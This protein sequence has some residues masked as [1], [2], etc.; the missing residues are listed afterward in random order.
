[1]SKLKKLKKQHKQ[2]KTKSDISF[3][4]LAVS[5]TSFFGLIFTGLG[6]NFNLIVI[7]LLPI[8]VGFLA[9]TIDLYVR[10]INKYKNTHFELREFRGLAV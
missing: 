7:S 1:M 8:S 3:M 2:H 6:L 9:F 5:V 4:L 10:M